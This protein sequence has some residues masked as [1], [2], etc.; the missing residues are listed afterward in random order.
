MAQR[1]CSLPCCKRTAARRRRCRQAARRL[2]HRKLPPRGHNPRKSRSRPCRSASSS[3]RPRRAS[4]ERSMPRDRLW[5]AARH[6]LGQ[7]LRGLGRQGAANA[8]PR[9]GLR[10]RGD[11]APCVRPLRR[12]APRRRDA[13]GHADLPRQSAL[14]RPEF[15]GPARIASAASTRTWRARSSSCTR[16][17]S[18]AAIRKA[19]SPRSRASSRAGRWSDARAG[20]AIR[21][22][23]PSSPTRMSRASRRCSAR[24]TPIGG[25]EQGKAALLDLARHPATARHIAAKLV[26]HFISDHVPAPLVEALAKVFRDSDGDLA[27]GGDGA[28]RPE[29]GLGAGSP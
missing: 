2:R 7:S 3:R 27:R 21:A 1:P 17:A 13:S 19:T 10:A 11:P 18:T 23:S 22:P 26:R 6:V 20:S 8:H 15:D 5:R 12:H 9:R 28:R 14:L 29:G 25:F 24:P 16:S 4:R